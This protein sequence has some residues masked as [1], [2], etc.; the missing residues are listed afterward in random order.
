MT[1]T[2]YAQALRA[3][4]NQLS[5]AGLT[6]AREDAR[7][8]LC[9]ACGLSAID[10]IQ[11]EQ[12][13]IAPAEHARYLAMIGRRASHQPLQ[14][15]LGRTSFYG[16]S[17]ICDARGLIP[18]DDSECVVDLALE[19]LP[20]GSG[21]VIADLGTGSG[22]LLAAL[23]TQRPQLTGT[24]IEQSPDAAALAAE[25]LMALGLTD[26]A[27]I[28]AQGWADWT[29]WRACD[30]IISNPPYIETAVIDTLDIEVRDHDPRAALDGGA[31]GLAAYREII[32]LA[33]AQ[34]KAGAHL[35]LEIGFDQKQAV[36]DLLITSG[37]TSLTHRKDLGGHDRAVAATHL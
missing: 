30:L 31:D 23:L 35:V 26:R 19:L 6:Y 34:M 13:Q 25:N 37:F 16:L 4:A 20:A 36:S 10:L 27:T 7:I 1:Q 3:G 9:A 29:G 12:G 28:A 33:A 17:L 32:R 18:R 11:R 24:G 15:I 14:H 22:A 21:G 8:L 5:A 2:S